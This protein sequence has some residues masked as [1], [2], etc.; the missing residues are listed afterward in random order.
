MGNDIG[1]K[2]CVIEVPVQLCQL[3][4]LLKKKNIIKV[5][6]ISLKFFFKLL[7]NNKVINNWD[8]FFGI[9]ISIVSDNFTPST[10]CIAATIV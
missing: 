2:S 9:V 7:L 6:S 5:R 8:D 4:A 10:V 3:S 1:F